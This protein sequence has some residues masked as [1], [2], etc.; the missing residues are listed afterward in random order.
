MVTKEEVTFLN[1]VAV[2]TSET[3]A[4]IY[5]STRCRIPEHQKINTAVKTSS[6]AAEVSNTR[7]SGFILFLTETIDNRLENQTTTTTT[8]NAVLKQGAELQS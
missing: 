4:N 1:V 8:T 7:T 2:S 3:S 5:Q 6:N